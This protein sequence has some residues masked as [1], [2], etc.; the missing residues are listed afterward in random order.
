MAVHSVTIVAA[1]QAAAT[2]LRGMDLDLH[3]RAARR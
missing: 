3:E 1:S 2:A